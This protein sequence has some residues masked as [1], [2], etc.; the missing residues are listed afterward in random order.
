MPEGA[1]KVRECGSGSTTTYSPREITKAEVDR[2]ISLIIAK[3][4][5]EKKGGVSEDY[6]KKLATELYDVPTKRLLMAEQY[7]LKATIKEGTKFFANGHD[8]EYLVLEKEYYT[9]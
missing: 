9:R 2:T 8:A 5:A 7:G 3:V 6:F 1:L 4:K